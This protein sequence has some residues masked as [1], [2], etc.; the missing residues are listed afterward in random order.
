MH[1]VFRCIPECALEKLCAFDFIVHGGP[2]WLCMWGVFERTCTGMRLVEACLSHNNTRHCHS[3]TLVMLQSGGWVNGSPE[4]LSAA[5]IF[6]AASIIGGY[7]VSAAFFLTSARF[8]G[9]DRAMLETVL[10]TGTLDSVRPN[11]AYAHNL[12]TLLQPVNW[13]ACITAAFCFQNCFDRSVMQVQKRC[14]MLKHTVA[15]MSL[16]HVISGRPV[17]ML[18][19]NAH[20]STWSCRWLHHGR[21][22]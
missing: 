16:G 14:L 19:T 21:R 11:Y 1:Q 18:N 5:R 20:P 22:S 10:Q 8:M 6:L 17:S 15:S 13:T 4:W 2:T 9:Q 3:C 12:A 7:Y